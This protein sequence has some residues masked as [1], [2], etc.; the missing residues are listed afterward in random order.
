MISLSVKWKARRSMIQLFFQTETRPTPS[1]ML[2][3]VVN[4]ECQG[5]YRHNLR[6]CSLQATQLQRL[7]FAASTLCNI[8]AVINHG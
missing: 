4:A 8:F 5:C 6:E 1:T 3:S 7:P 2:A